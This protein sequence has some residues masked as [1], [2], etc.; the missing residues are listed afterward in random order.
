[1][2]ATEIPDART[3]AQDNAVSNVESQ[4]AINALAVARGLHSE[5]SHALPF[6]LK[7]TR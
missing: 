1:V 5:P 6:S 7:A 3:P 2:I 4:A